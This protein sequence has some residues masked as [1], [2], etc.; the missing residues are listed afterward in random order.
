MK[1]V[2]LELYALITCIITIRAFFKKYSTI[3]CFIWLAYAVSAVFCVLCKLY[4]PVLVG[5]GRY[6]NYWYDLSDTTWWGYGLILVCNLIA[7]KPFK[8]FDKEYDLTDFGINPKMQNFFT[9]FSILYILLAL[10]FILPSIGNI[11][12]V[13]HITDLGDLRNNLFANSENEGSVVI[14]SNFISNFCFKMCLLMKYIAMYISFGMIKQKRTP[15][16]CS[17]LIGFTFFLV[18]IN[19]KATAARGGLLIFVFGV[20]LIGLSFY[21]YLSASNKRKV[22]I[23]GGVVAFIMFSFVSAV[24][25]SRFQNDGG[26]GNPILRNI[27]F[28]L[29]HGPIEFSKITGSLNDFAYGRTIMGRLSNHYFGTEYSWNSVAV[30]IGYPN[31]G[32]LFVTYLGFLYTDFGVIGCLTFT[33]IWS[34]IT[35]I[36]IIKRPNNISTIYFFLYYLSFYVTGIFSVGRLEYAAVI[37]TTIIYFIIRAIEMDPRIKRLFTIKIKI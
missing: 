34:S 23:I 3:Y 36:L 1:L 31:I 14:A 6:H 16:L 12:R 29:G 37:T 35:Q 27:C 15:V 2:Y 11:I 7:F 26:G 28:Y 5:I 33:F 24:T 20:F 10:G 25:I 13:L 9:I 22:V 17:L 4:Q 30:S 8:M 19:S 32:A 18:Y 21:K